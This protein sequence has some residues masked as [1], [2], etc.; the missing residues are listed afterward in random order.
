MIDAYGWI[1]YRQSV[2]SWITAAGRVA[3]QA[4]VH[5]DRSMPILTRSL[6]VHRVELVSAPVPSVDERA[7]T[8]RA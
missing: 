1:M 2:E 6:R 4:I 7:A 5:A 3:P 8:P